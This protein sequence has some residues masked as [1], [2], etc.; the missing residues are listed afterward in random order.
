MNKY[1]QS[2]LWGEQRDDAYAMRTSSQ[3]FLLTVRIREVGPHQRLM[4]T[5]VFH[6]GG[7]KHSEHVIDVSDQ[8][9]DEAMAYGF[10]HCA[11]L[12]E[13]AKPR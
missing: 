9:N 3:D 11:M 2:E 10:A 13:G 7:D 4:L 12:A 5:Q 6:P 8:N 1:W